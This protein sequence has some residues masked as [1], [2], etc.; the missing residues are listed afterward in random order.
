MHNTIAKLKVNE[1]V[2]KA[3]DLALWAV[4]ALKILMVPPCKIYWGKHALLFTIF[5]CVI[6][7]CAPWGK[8]VSKNLERI[9]ELLI[10]RKLIM[11][12]EVLEHLKMH[13]PRMVHNMIT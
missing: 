12:I 5:V 1:K 4:I 6:N 3:A 11:T 9:H 13:I 2:T 10:T 7:L 8:K